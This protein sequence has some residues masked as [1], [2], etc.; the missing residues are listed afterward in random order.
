M[1]HMMTTGEG[2]PAGNSV[3]NRPLLSYTTETQICVAPMSNGLFAGSGQA[4]VGVNW[5]ADEQAERWYLTELD[6]A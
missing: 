3:L 5:K 6:T 2:K 1:R 4:L